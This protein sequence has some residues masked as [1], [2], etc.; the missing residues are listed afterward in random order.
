MLISASNHLPEEDSLRA[1]FDRFLMRVTSENVPAERLGEV[2][3]AGWRLD[4]KL[5]SVTPTYTVDDV[6][7]LHALLP[8]VDLA[9]VH[10]ETIELVARLRRAGIPVSDR[11]AVKLQRLVAASAL[12]SGRSAAIPSDLWVFRHSWDTLEQQEVLAALVQESLR[13]VPQ[14]AGDHPR[15][16]GNE[17]PDAEQLARDLDA[18]GA[19]LAPKE[20]RPAPEVLAVLRDRLGVLAGRCQWVKQESQREALAGR[21]EA[22]WAHFEATP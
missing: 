20:P 3:L 6:R 8:G 5:D 18:I 22:L 14:D 2:L 19:A 13:K 1:L 9:P 21:V 15:A 4:L 11:R 17:A 7:A 16:R 12:I 10:Q